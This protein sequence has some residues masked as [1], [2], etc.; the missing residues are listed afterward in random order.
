MKFG[1]II[2]FKVGYFLVE[3]RGQ[4][5]RLQLGLWLDHI[6]KSTSRELKVFC[7]ET[8]TIYLRTYYTQYSTA[9]LYYIVCVSM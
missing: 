6:M 2:G 9:T 8:N 7:Q 1:S 5:F 4:Y 3:E